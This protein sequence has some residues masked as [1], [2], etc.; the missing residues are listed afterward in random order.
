[1][2]ASRIIEPLTRTGDCWNCSVTLH[3]P[4]HRAFSPELLDSVGHLGHNN[5][6]PVYLLIHA[7]FCAGWHAVHLRDNSIQFSFPL[8]KFLIHVFTIV[9][10]LHDIHPFVSSTLSE[11]CSDSDRYQPMPNIKFD[12]E[13]SKPAIM[14]ME[15]TS[16]LIR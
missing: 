6:Q 9:V 13:R 12:L 2:Y 4:G 10:D 3:L 15:H 7:L 16:L 11:M 8:G 5:M 1:M 14:N